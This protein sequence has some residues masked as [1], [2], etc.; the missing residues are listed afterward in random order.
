MSTE[1]LR[2]ILKKF[3]IKANYLEEQYKQKHKEDF[4][5]KKMR[6]YINYKLKKE[7][8]ILTFCNIMPSI[9]A[10]RSSVYC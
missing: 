8:K 3:E 10:Q 1:Q 5:E 9:I 7:I 4:D 6:K 2:L